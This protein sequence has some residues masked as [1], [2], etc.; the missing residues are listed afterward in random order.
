MT[1]RDLAA[2][3]ENAQDAI[4]SKDLDAVITSWNA[5]AQRMYG[6]TPEEAIGQPVTLLVPP[7]RH[8]E[9]T[10]IMAR[11]RRGEVIDHYITQ[12][13]TKDGRLLDVSLMV[14]PIRDRKGEVVAAS[15]IARDVTEEVTAHRKTARR[16]VAAY[17]LIVFFGMTGFFRM[18]QIS[19]KIDRESKRRSYENCQ[20]V[21]RSNTV[22][23]ALIDKSAAPLTPPANST[24]EL[25]QV[26][27]DANERSA[28]FGDFA[29]K[30]L[31]D[32][33]CKHLE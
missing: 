2:I 26:F 29:R 31:A 20:A 14:S 19:H 4:F 23:R 18:E 5:G 6:Y 1:A 3:V 10:A 24:P 33:D 16:Q 9:I 21:V 32:P 8:G 25:R 17:V 28:A 11:I 30:L 12:R 15:T 7:D 22:L 27:I 13:R